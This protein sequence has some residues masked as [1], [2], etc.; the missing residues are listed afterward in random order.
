MD[1]IKN[2]IRQYWPNLLACVIFLAAT[3]RF[4]RLGD[5]E[6]HWV[7]FAWAFFGFISVVA[8]E[9]V[10][11]WTGRYGWTRQQWRQYPSGLVRRAGGAVLVVATIVLYRS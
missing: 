3:L 9:E 1:L 5:W 10:A 2:S 11:E 7:P 8:S 4:V 6:Q